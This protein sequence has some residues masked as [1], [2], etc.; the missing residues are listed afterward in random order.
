MIAADGWVN[1]AQP[2]EIVRVKGK[3]NKPRLARTARLPEGQAAIQVGSRSRPDSGSPLLRRRARFASKHLTGSLPR[4]SNG[5]TR[6]AR[7]DGG[8]DD[9][10]LAEVITGTGD[11]PEDSRHHD[12]EQARL[13]EIGDDP[14]YADERV[15]LER[16]F[17]IV[18]AGKQ[19]DVNSKR[20]AG[21]KDLDGKIDSKLTPNSQRPRSR[22]WWLTTSGW[23]HL[24]AAVE[25]EI[26]CVS[27]ALTS[28]VRELAERYA[29]V[30]AGSSPTKVSRTFGS[31]C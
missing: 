25:S 22:R 24:S 7:S 17:G 16:V 1:G 4:W 2:R 18:A 20:K 31:L 8:E 5:S 9:E 10:L 15:V 26:E 29:D 21:Q 14:V 30:S 27:Q 23:K 28:R 3:N 11:K 12:R 6:C 13:K 19:S